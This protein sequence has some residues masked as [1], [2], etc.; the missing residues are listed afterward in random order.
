M[1]I[2]EFRCL[3]CNEYFE[4]L[5]INPEEKIDLRCPKCKS[6]QF[7]RVMSRASYTMAE[8]RTGVKS[9]TKTCSSGSCTS[10]EM[11]GP[12]R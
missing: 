12:T 6:E 11:P 2:Y 3:N 5:L 4:W 7:E 1:P 8:G 10:W 9:S